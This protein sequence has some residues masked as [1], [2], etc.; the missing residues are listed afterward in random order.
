MI[1]GSL[2]EPVDSTHRDCLEAVEWVRGSFSALRHETAR[3]EPAPF[4]Y[5]RV[6]ILWGDEIVLPSRRGWFR[7]LGTRQAH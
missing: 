3:W 5:E 2:L 6:E 7:S 4:P 1:A